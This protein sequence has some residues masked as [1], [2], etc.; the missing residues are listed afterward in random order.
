MRR[1]GQVDD[2]PLMGIFNSPFGPVLFLLGLFQL[3]SAQ[4][5]TEYINNGVSSTQELLLHCEQQ[6]GIRE[7][8]EW[9]LQE[10]RCVLKRSV[11]TFYNFHDYEDAIPLQSLDYGNFEVV[12]NY[13]ECDE[14]RQKPLLTVSRE[15]RLHITFDVS[16]LP[17][18]A[19]LYNATFSISADYWDGHAEQPV[20]L[21]LGIGQVYPEENVGEATAIVK[22]TQN[23]TLTV[24]PLDVQSTANIKHILESQLSIMRTDKKFSRRQGKPHTLTLFLE[25]NTQSNND[26][27][28]IKLHSTRSG[29]KKRKLY[30]K[31]T[32][33]VSDETW[34]AVEP[35]TIPIN[36]ST[37]YLV[38]GKFDMNEKY[39]CSVVFL[40]KKSNITNQIRG[41]A[42]LPNSTTTLICEIP[43]IL[44]DYEKQCNT[45]GSW[46]ISGNN[47]ARC[48]ETL[49]FRVHRLFR[50][51]V[52]IVNT[53][54]FIEASR[55][56]IDVTYDGLDLTDQYLVISTPNTKR[57]ATYNNQLE[58]PG[59]YSG[60]NGMD[61]SYFGKSY[62]PNDFR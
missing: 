7:S 30:P 39:A 41:E 50:K 3:E 40:P 45:T 34:T 5:G 37:S 47:W 46:H 4:S 55:H 42:M 56:F 33:I 35:R 25:W 61:A 32:V 43:K 8:V 54:T 59:G 24:R 31:M 16:R 6:T 11:E 1:S 15:C 19:T 60:W 14:W 29:Y 49:Q 48:Y 44:K 27:S 17:S 51:I 62:D 53:D 12:D 22:A 52:P 13:D 20:V 28:Y 36:R 21:D 57:P 38:N 10:G 26:A 18:S 23:T 58:R 2:E 9:D